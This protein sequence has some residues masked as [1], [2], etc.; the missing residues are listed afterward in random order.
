MLP[1]VARYVY[2]VYQTKNV[3]QAASELFISQP[4]L[5]AAI[6]RAEQEI[7]APIFNRKTL[8][9]TLTPEGKVYI[10]A[11]ERMIAIEE[12]MNDR[13]RDIRHTH[14]GRLRIGVSTRLAHFIIPAILNAFHG[15]YPNVD[16]HIQNVSTRKLPNLLEDE[17]VDMLF[18]PLDLLS[19]DYATVPLLEERL[20]VAVR[21]DMLDPSLSAYAIDYDVLIGRTYDDSRTVTDLPLL[22]KMDFTYTPPNTA[23]Y[24]KRRILLSDN[25]MMP[26]VLSNSGNLQ[27][28]YNLMLAGV[29]ACLSTDAGIATLPKNDKVTHLVIGGEHGRQTFGIIYPPT[30][31]SPARDAFIETAVARFSDSNP[32]PRLAKI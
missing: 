23:V 15:Q 32:L 31:S 14:G 28:Y 26:Y 12:Q 21:R 4:A 5:S 8:P 22:R 11:I 6:K 1:T 9:L 24:K 30:V 7:G 17:T 16:V 20:T 29:G 13:I 18:A 19:T 25:E 3:S 27:L 10:E 2:K